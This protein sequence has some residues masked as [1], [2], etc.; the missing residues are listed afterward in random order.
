MHAREASNELIITMT[1]PDHYKQLLCERIYKKLLEDKRSESIKRGNLLSENEDADIKRSFNQVMQ[2]L[3][4]INFVLKKQDVNTWLLVEDDPKRYAEELEIDED[5]IN[6]WEKIYDR[7][8][9]DPIG[10]N[11]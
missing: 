4:D 2:D 9:P 8:D 10:V 5:Y 11:V 7:I 6:R 3:E 1:L